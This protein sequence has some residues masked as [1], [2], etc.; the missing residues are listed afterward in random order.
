[1]AEIVEGGFG[2]Y[3]HWPFC[4]AK[5]PY[6]DFNSHVTR[7]V[8]H[9]A[10][11]DAYVR[12]I[13]RLAAETGDQRLDSVYFG[14]GTPS[15]MEPATV[16]A[17]LDAVRAGWSVA[18]DWE[19]TLE[20]NPT[21]VEAARFAG[22]REAGV[23]RVSVG[24]QALDDA[25]LKA[26]GRLHSKDEALAALEVARST[27]DRV[28]FDLIYARQGQSLSDWRDE[29]LRGL[30][31]GTDHLSL[32][33]LTIEPGTAFWDRKQAGGLKGL[34]DEDLGADLYEATAELCA[35]HG[36]EAYEVSNFARDGARS[37]HNLIYWNAGDWGGIG[38]GAHG[39][40]TLGGE[41]IATEQT[42]LPKD[43]L[44]GVPDGRHESRHLLSSLDRA[45]EYLMMGLRLR[46][47][48][49]LT[50][51]ESMA[52]RPLD[53]NRLTDLEGYGLV[54]RS[55]SRLAVT[56]AGRMVLNRVVSELLLE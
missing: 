45:N 15:L 49:S 56:E 16:Q 50:R 13:A 8:D 55:G 2:L 5:C 42:L 54:E 12:E 19:V 34:P 22:Y 27:F 11:A 31:L 36:F 20:A 6:C 10:W 7:T 18:N 52:G 41:R 25:S 37:T 17:I 46:D 1:M 48:I 14:G 38:P 23:N 29:L 30:D 9:G 33:Q 4:A 47:G 24:V 21:S 26:L 28:S 35:E 39:R 32:Y 51:L 43:W 3:I 40:L 53:A 44:A